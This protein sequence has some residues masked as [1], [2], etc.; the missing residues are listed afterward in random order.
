MPEA[1]AKQGSRKGDFLGGK[2][3]LG[4]CL[5]I[6]G[7]GEVYRAQNVSLGRQVAIKILSAEF[8]KNEDDEKRFL[9]EARAAAAVRHPHV[10]DVLDVARDDDG[11]PFIVQELLSGQDL[12]QHLQAM[13]GRM[14]PLEVLEVMI[15]VADAVGAAHRQGVVHR[16]LKPANIF[17]ARDGMRIVPKVLDFG[18]AL[19]KTV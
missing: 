4:D 13:G 1:V 16:D 5:G 7:M 18:A 10:V 3:L 12:E 14:T 17:L 15:P 8:V 2:Y 19:Y 9:R 11:T 6:G